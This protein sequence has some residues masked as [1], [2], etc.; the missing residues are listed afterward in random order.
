[1][2]RGQHKALANC[3]AFENAI[4][5]PESTENQGSK[6]LKAAKLVRLSLNPEVQGGD[7]ASLRWPRYPMTGTSDA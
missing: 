6:L 2:R 3:R 4:V 5:S 1:M 7:P